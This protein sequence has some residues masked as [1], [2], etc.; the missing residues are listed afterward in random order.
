[1]VYA[2]FDVTWYHPFFYICRFI[3]MTDFRSIFNHYLI[4]PLLTVISRYDCNGII[5]G[6][7]QQ[8]IKSTVKLQFPW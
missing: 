4:C 3:E 1:M 5:T 7:V 2:H 6:C 8:P